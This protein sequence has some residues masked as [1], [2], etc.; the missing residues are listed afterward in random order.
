MTAHGS[1]LGWVLFLDPGANPRAPE[2]QH[3]KGMLG[4]LRVD[5]SAGQALLRSPAWRS[6]LCIS[7]GSDVWFAPR[8]P[9]ALFT[10]SS[11]GRSAADRQTA[12]AE[13]HTGASRTVVPQVVPKSLSLAR[14]APG[15]TCTRCLRGWINPGCLLV[16]FL[17][18]LG[19]CDRLLKQGYEEGQ[20][21]EAMEMFQHSEKKVRSGQHSPAISAASS[22]PAFPAGWMF[23]HPSRSLLV[24]Q[25]HRPA[26]REPALAAHVTIG[27]PR[28]G[29]LLRHSSPSILTPSCK[30]DA[31]SAAA[32][33]IPRIEPTRPCYL[34]PASLSAPLQGEELWWHTRGWSPSPVSSWGE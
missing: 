18:Y 22:G 25:T 28:E 12:L 11:R 8:P 23:H 2:S 24:G 9:S 17:S 1:P 31:R 5:I 26:S 34:P 6:S 3:I 4:Q 14:W 21:E 20:V 15:C 10:L 13:H 30:H 33:G 7:D 27:T 29:Q 16:Q 32:Q 19:A